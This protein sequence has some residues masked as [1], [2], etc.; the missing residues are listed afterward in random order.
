MFDVSSPS[1]RAI[2]PLTKSGELVLEGARDGRDRRLRGVTDLSQEHGIIPEP[3]AEGDDSAGDPLAQL[4][5]LLTG[6]VAQRRLEVT[7]DP[8]RPSS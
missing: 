5:L 3:F 2:V 1:H 8:T 6:L 4:G 7:P